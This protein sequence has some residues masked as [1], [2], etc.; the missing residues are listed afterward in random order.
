M[1]TNVM[2]SGKKKLFRGKTIEELKKIDTR[3]FAKFLKSR[4]RR[5]VMRNFNVIENFAKR[6]EK[7][8]IKKKVP[9]THNRA[10]VI[11]PAFVGMSIG[12]HNGKDYVL[13]RVTEEMLGHRFGEFALTRRAVKH[14]A[15]GVGATK[16]S[17]SL[18]VK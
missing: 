7:K 4:E 13:V 8:I 11:T 6:C 1:V 10:L 16:S 3:E 5:S 9:K 17:S 12:V 2:V 14:G 18:S 15:A